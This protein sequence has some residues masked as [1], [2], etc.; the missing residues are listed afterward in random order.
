MPGRKLVGC[1]RTYSSVRMGRGAPNTRSCVPFLPSHEFHIANDDPLMFNTT[2]A[3]MM[4]APKRK[5]LRCSHSPTWERPNENHEHTSVQMG[6][7]MASR[8]SLICRSAPASVRLN[9]FAE[10]QGYALT[11]PQLMTAATSNVNAKRTHRTGTAFALGI[12]ALAACTPKAF[13]F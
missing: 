5:R 10:N 11:Q 3:R 7:S 8:N 6:N 2:A 4:A 13:S 9:T 12:F 1:P